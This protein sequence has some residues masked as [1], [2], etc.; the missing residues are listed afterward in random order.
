MASGVTSF[1]QL[2]DAPSFS[3]VTTALRPASEVRSTA[4]A[5]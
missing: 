2:S 3:T 4:F 1:A 5:G